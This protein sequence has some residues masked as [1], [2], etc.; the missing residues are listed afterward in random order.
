MR[1]CLIAGWWYT[2]AWEFK[3]WVAILVNVVEGIVLLSESGEKV[4]EVILWSVPDD[5]KVAK[6]SFDLNSGVITPVNIISK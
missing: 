6:V 4:I 5:K 2:V 1:C 3:S